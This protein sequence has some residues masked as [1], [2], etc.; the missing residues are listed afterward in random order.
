MLPQTTPLYATVWHPGQA[1]EPDGID[2]AVWLVIA[3]TIRDFQP[4]QPVIVKL[5]G[6]NGPPIVW[7]FPRPDDETAPT[8]D[9][10]DSLAEAQATIRA[11]PEDR[12]R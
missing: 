5:S 7:D 9:Y 3:W 4:D 1:G 6:H 8:L 11:Y 12:R 2:N 10:A